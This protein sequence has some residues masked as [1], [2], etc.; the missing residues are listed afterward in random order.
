MKYSH[1]FENYNIDLMAVRHNLFEFPSEFKNSLSFEELI[2]FLRDPHAEDPQAIERVL[3]EIE[4]LPENDDILSE[5]V[6]ARKRKNFLT[7][8]KD[9]KTM[10]EIQKMYGKFE[11]FCVLSE[12][13]LDFLRQAFYRLANTNEDNAL[14]DR[15]S[16]TK[17]LREDE[18]V[19]KILREA[20]VYISE[21][22]EYV[23][24]ERVLRQIEND[25]RKAPPRLKKSKEKVSLIQFLKFFTN[26]E[27][28]K[29]K[30]LD[31][32]EDY[33]ENTDD[34]E[35]IDVKADR[36]QFFKDIYDSIPKDKFGLAD[37]ETFLQYLRET[38]YYNAVCEETAR[39]KAILFDLSTETIAETINRVSKEG[40]TNLHWD[41][42]KQFFTRRGRPLKLILSLTDIDGSRHGSKILDK[43]RL[44]QSK[45]ITYKMRL[46]EAL[47]EEEGKYFKLKK[48]NFKL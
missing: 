6:A 36:L 9:E 8:V 32:E 42:F 34:S 29:T 5:T 44:P 16:F 38:E 26:Y 43:D 2:A 35:E 40:D 12:E 47:E 18:N 25:L 1:A 10:H 22:D 17:Q 48:T 31:E 33:E 24:L 7:S 15:I 4:E 21:Y 45:D 37:K 11:N 19:R 14:I 46:E 3:K 39:Q 13:K 41:D 28:N 23:S 27:L 30:G 20:A